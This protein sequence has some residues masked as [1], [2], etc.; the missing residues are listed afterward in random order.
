[1]KNNNVTNNKK[2]PVSKMKKLTSGS[3]T[4]EL[5]KLFFDFL[6]SL[7]QICNVFLFSLNLDFK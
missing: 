1:M 7:L 3:S 4:N 6:I 2:V 5:L